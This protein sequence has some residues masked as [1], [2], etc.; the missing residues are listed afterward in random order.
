MDL[1]ELLTIAQRLREYVGNPHHVDPMSDAFKVL[2]DDASNALSQASKRAPVAWRGCNA[3]GEVVTEWI[4]GVPPERM[5]DL[6]GNAAS[7][8][9]IE[10]AYAEQNPQR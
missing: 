2:I 5:T 8:D 9:K 10:Y 3:D 1:N 7:F 4:D 6:C